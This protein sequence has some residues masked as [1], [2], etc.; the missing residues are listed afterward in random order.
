VIERTGKWTEEEINAGSIGAKIRTTADWA[1]RRASLQVV[2]NSVFYPMESVLKSSVDREWTWC[3]TED[4]NSKLK[5][6]VRRYGDKN[7]DEIRSFQVERRS[8]VIIDGAMP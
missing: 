7:W 1:Q 3:G 4:E 6:A 8:S 2:Q 5:T